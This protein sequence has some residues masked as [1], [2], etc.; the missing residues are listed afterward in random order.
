MRRGK[1]LKLITQQNKFVYYY[2]EKF[3]DLYYRNKIFSEGEKLL[4]EAKVRAKLFQT[5]HGGK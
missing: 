2:G 4:I 3:S 5:K 1:I